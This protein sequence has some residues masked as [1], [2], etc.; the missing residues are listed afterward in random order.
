[1]IDGKIINFMKMCV[2][3]DWKSPGFFFGKVCFHPPFAIMSC[4]LFNLSYLNFFF[5]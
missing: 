3:F 4:K 5:F 1:M 2:G